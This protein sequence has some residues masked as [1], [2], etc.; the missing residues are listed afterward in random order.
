MKV[1][2]SCSY[3]Q[4]IITTGISEVQGQQENSQ[5]HHDDDVIN[6]QTG[7][8]IMNHDSGS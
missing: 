3:Y 6:V 2:A 1:F 7:V 8:F 4:H 5:P